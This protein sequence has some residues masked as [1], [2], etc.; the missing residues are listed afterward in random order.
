MTQE[1]TKLL[2]QEELELLITDLCGRLPYYLKV[3]S[4]VAN[5]N[6]AVLTPVVIS[7]LMNADITMPQIKPYLRPASSMTPDEVAQYTEMWACRDAYNVYPACDWLNKH[8]IDFRGLIE[9][10]LALEAPEDMY[11]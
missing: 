3:W 8:H 2:T 5:G 10:G 9:M 7:N 4:P 6:W 11:T 1:N